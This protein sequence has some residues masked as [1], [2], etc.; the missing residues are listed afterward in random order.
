[1]PFD[2]KHTTVRIVPISPI[3]YR[4]TDGRPEHSKAYMD[5]PDSMKLVCTHFIPSGD[6]EVKHLNDD[7]WCS[8]EWELYNGMKVLVHKKPN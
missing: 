4:A 8:P 1:M 5:T 3:D 2:P 7:C 6:D